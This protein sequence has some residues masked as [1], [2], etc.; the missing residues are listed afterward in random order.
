MKSRRKVL[1]AMTS[2]EACISDFVFGHLEAKNILVEDMIEP[3]VG[4]NAGHRGG[5]RRGFSDG[6]T[7]ERR[8]V[9]NKGR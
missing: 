2:I 6:T 7:V 4:I 5:V 9:D 3:S 1:D 8:R